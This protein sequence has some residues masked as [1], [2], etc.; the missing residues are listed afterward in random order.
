MSSGTPREWNSRS[1]HRLSDP[2]YGWAQKVLGR[3]ELRGDETVLDAGCG[4]GRVTAELA[5]RLPRGRILALDLSENM[6]RGAR[7]HLTS[8]N[9][10]VQFAIA[11]L[12]AVPLRGESFDGVFSTAVFHWIIDQP[13]LFREL[14]RA[15]KPG[16]WLDAQCGGG[17]NLKSIQDRVDAIIARPEYQDFFREWNG[18]WN[19][20]DAG[21]ATVRLRDAGFEDVEAWLEHSP[22]PMNDSATYREYLETVTLHRHAARI[23]DLGLRELFFDELVRLAAED[24][25]PYVMD[26]WRLNMRG[27]KL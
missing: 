21:V 25:P 24:D 26:Y 19:Y 11:N 3:L 12:T 4:T 16:G 20:V 27:K 23:T 18:V 14:F 7:E 17:P 9:G 15:L 5:K 1:Y 10:R 22:A 6:V 13:K 2:Q 8:A